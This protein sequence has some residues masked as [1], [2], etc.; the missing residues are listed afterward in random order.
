MK[1]FS[2]K[3]APVCIFAI[4]PTLRY[5][6]E[7]HLCRRSVPSLCMRLHW[8]GCFF[9]PNQACL[10]GSYSDERISVT[11]VR[12]GGSPVTLGPVPPKILS[13]GPSG[14][15]QAGPKWVGPRWAQVGGPTPGPSW[16][17]VGPSQKFG[18]QKSPKHKNSQNQNPFCPKCWQGF[19]MPEKSVPA[20]F[21]AIWDHFF[22]GP[23]KF[24]KCPNFAYFPW[25]AHGP[26]SPGLEQWLLFVVGQSYEASPDLQVVEVLIGLQMLYL[27]LLH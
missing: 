4:C 24:K 16:A 17:Q 23:G 19:F 9:L 6:G 14:L 10:W 7:R 18:T 21:W 1:P 3:T 5:M 2:S 11:G 25:W 22:R 26:Y 27:S 15:A 8:H 13:V 12:E 20:P